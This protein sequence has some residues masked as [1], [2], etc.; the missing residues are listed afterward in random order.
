M[1]KSLLRLMRSAELAAAGR[2]GRGKRQRKGEA[3]GEPVENTD[4]S[5][6]FIATSRV[7]IVC[8]C[9]DQITVFLNSTD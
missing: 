3:Y 9:E 8:M 7:N 4:L 2:P 1:P 5:P 6:G